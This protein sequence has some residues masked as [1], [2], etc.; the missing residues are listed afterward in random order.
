ME[1]VTASWSDVLARINQIKAEHRR[2]CITNC[3]TPLEQFPLRMLSSN[4][5]VVFACREFDFNR[6][7]YFSASVN[8]LEKLLAEFNIGRDSVIGY[9]DK[10]RNEDLCA[11]FGAAGYREK[12]HYRRM[13]NHQIPVR[14]VSYEP[15]FA[16]ED[17]A[18]QL[19][20][21]LNETFDP[22]IDHLPQLPRMKE[23]V[24]GKQA[25]VSRN[26]GRITGALI[27]QQVGKQVNYNY[28]VNRGGPTMDLL[29]LQNSFYHVM[30]Q[31]NIT[32]GFLWV[33]NNNTGVIKL[34]HAFGWKFDGLNDWF[35]TRTAI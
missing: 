8:S 33:N 32:S 15:E 20:G 26:M 34:H 5:A 28:L 21:L 1:T 27:F 13:S 14:K 29:A 31:R 17:E 4:S 12:A 23:I 22:M 19:L 24:V 16:H 3:F 25:I 9:V 18:E 2:Q 6:I 11:A 10:N 35:Y 7:Y 30:A